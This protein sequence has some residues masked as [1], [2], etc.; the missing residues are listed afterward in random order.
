MAN[1][2]SVDIVIHGR[3]GHGARPHMAADPIVTASYLVTALQ[4]LVSRRLD[5]QSPGVVTV[6]SI[7]A[8]TK[9]NVIPD[10]AVLQL[11]VRSYSDDDRTL[12]IEGIRQL[13]NDVCTSFRC[14]SPPEVTV[15]DEYTPAVYNDPALTARA[16]ALFVRELG[17]ENVIEVK[18]SMGG[19]DFGRYA[20]ALQVPGL[21]YRL[22]VVDRKAWNRQRENGGVPFP[23]LHSSRF[24]PEA[25]PALATGVRTMSTLALDLLAR[26]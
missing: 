13:A 14:A 23:S 6:G 25:R 4:T 22:G 26:H 21:L 17:A 2:D 18:P 10:D 9:H 16:V 24:A 15:K 7:H 5:P 19:E 3:G 11:T 8:G 12:L 1:V 20:R